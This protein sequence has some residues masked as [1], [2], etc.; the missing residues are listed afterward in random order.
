MKN[1]VSKD[2]EKRQRVIHTDYSLYPKDIR[3]FLEHR[4]EIYKRWENSPVNIK[5]L[6]LLIDYVEEKIKLIL[7]LDGE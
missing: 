1:A 4:K 7:D 2:Y 5:E 3:Q 6:E